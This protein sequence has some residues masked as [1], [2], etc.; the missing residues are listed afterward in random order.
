[1]YPCLSTFF[2]FVVITR[3]QVVP[4]AVAQNIIVK[5][6]TN[7]KAKPAEILIRLRAWFGDDE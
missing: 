2:L 4:S 6:I 3:E 7:E 1:M 5:F